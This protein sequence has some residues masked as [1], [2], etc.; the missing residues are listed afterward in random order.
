MYLLSPLIVQGCERKFLILALHTADAS[1]LMGA[2]AILL[3]F[4][5]CFWQHLLLNT[6]HKKIK[7]VQALRLIIERWNLING[8]T[9]S[10]YFR[11]LPFFGTTTAP[12][13]F[14]SE[15]WLPS[16]YIYCTRALG[17]EQPS[18]QGMWANLIFQYPQQAQRHFSPVNKIGIC[19]QLATKHFRDFIWL[20]A[21]QLAFQLVL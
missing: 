5:Q 15:I 3:A 6:A 18:K 20:Q 13:F 4:S 11:Q 7:V 9:N 2:F 8:G 21:F 14:Q 10:F 1:N 16:K 17:L 12:S 19:L